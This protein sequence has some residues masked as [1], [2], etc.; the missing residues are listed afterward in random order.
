ME[1]ADRRVGE[2]GE[3]LREVT[4]RVEPVPAAGAGQA[5]ED[6][7]RLATARGV[8]EERVL[9]QQGNPLHLLLGQISVDRHGGVGGE[10]RQLPP[11]IQHIADRLGQRMLG[12]Q[13]RL[14]LDQQRVQRFE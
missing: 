14:L 9:P 12:Q 11:L 1:P 5:A 6:R 7:G 4:L 10:Q 8:G 2:V 3:Q 13:L